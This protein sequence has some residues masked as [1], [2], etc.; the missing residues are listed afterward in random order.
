MT[1]Q[2]S[3]VE[4][5]GTLPNETIHIMPR[6]TM[7]LHGHRNKVVPFMKPFIFVDLSKGAKICNYTCW[8]INNTLIHHFLCQIT[9][10]HISDEDL[11]L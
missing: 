11:V 9:N 5:I 8:L 6:C 1:S 2:S 10:H 3:I 4:K 7:H